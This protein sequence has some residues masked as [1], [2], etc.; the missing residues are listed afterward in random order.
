[1][2]E[3]M[4]ESRRLGLEGVV[5][6]R[7]RA[8]Y[9]AG[10]RSRDWLKIKHAAAQETVVVG[11]RPLRSGTP[12]QDVGS[13]GGLL[14]A[15]PDG[16]HLRYVGRVGSGFSDRER[17]DLAARLAP[18]DTPPLDGVPALDARGAR[19]VEPDVVVEVLHAGWTEDAPGAG[20]L[21]HPVWRGVRPDKHP[22]QVRV[23]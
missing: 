21:R 22:D 5:A 8:G 11:W 13:V 1:V 15:V 14:L 16:D 9:A 19:W 2:A 17:R 20:S 18:R 12:T 23:E 10:R 6:K 7:R 3:A 4:A